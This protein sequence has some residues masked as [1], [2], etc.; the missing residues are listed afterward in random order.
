MYPIGLTNLNSKHTDLFDANTAP[1][2]FAPGLG[3][4]AK[5]VEAG[6]SVTVTDLKTALLAIKT[7]VEQGE[8]EVPDDIG[9]NHLE[10]DHY[11]IFSELRKEDDIKWDT[12]PL[13]NE[14]AT[15][16]YYHLDK[17]IYQVRS[18]ASAFESPTCPFAHHQS[19]H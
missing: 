1:F 8:G 2:Q 14:P 13:I 12:H 16:D 15:E 7:I 11:D 5:N 19:P 6:G 4:Q 3:Y 9:M 17:R 18:I 10:K